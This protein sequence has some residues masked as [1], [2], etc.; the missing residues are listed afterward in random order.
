MGYYNIP[1]LPSQIDELLYDWQRAEILKK[2]ESPI[3][4]VTPNDPIWPV[5]DDML[6]AENNILSLS[7]SGEINCS[8]H[9]LLPGVNAVW[10]LED[11]D[12]VGGSTPVEAILINTSDLHSIREG[13]I[14]SLI[15]HHLF[16]GF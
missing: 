6:V 9:E 15:Q 3:V 11:W 1:N 13:G 7:K 5:L 8:V 16:K 14:D 4:T 2:V 12:V 10:I